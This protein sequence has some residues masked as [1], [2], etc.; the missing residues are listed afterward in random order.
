MKVV[1]VDYGSGNIA[2]VKMA[3]SR[4]GH[5]A[6][7]SNREDEIYAADKVIFPGVGH[8]KAAMQQLKYHKLDEVIPK[9]TQPL[10]GICLGMQLMCSHSEEGSTE[11]LGIFDAPVQQFPPHPE[12]KVP[13]MGWN[14]I[15]T[16]SLGANHAQ[17][18]LPGYVYFV[19]SYFVPLHANTTALANYIVPFS[20][21]LQRDNFF[22]TQFHPEKSGSL[23]AQILQNFLKL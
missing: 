5:E 12:F 9:L 2:S 7:L 14:L 8:A 15:E 6:I 1:I 17:I 10:L 11:A 19:H 22:A 23:G 18:E 4:L 20:A 13:H 16:R 21:A 3:L